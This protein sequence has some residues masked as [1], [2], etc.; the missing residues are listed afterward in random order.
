MS[1]FEVQANQK[2][3]FA[4]IRASAGSSLLFCRWLVMQIACQQRVYRKLLNFGIV[5]VA[6]GDQLLPIFGHCPSS[7]Q[8]TL[9]K[10]RGNETT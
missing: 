2:T 7:T 5:K 4:A 8:L 3:S 10:R 9:T 6:S 1:N